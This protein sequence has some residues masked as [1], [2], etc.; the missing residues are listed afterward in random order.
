MPDHI[1]L[2]LIP[3]SSLILCFLH[4]F[5]SFPNH[6]KACCMNQGNTEKIT[7]GQFDLH[8]AN[9]QKIRI[10]YSLFG[11]NHNVMTKVSF[12]QLLKYIPYFFNKSKSGL[13]N[14]FSRTCF[15]NGRILKIKLDPFTTAAHYLRLKCFFNSKYWMT[16]CIWHSKNL[17]L[18]HRT[19]WPWVTYSILFWYSLFEENYTTMVWSKISINLLALLLL[20]DI[21]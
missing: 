12:H 5:H 13:G 11:N 3:K 15:E 20:T 8:T 18:E 19:A 21:K 10:Y 16:L 4:F 1:L 14:L 7:Y 2:N 17:K 9:S 6:C